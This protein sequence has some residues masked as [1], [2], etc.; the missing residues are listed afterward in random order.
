MD[1]F[2]QLPAK[3]WAFVRRIGFYIKLGYIRTV[4]LIIRARRGEA[5]E[6]HP[7]VGKW[8]GIIFKVIFGVAIFVLA[9]EIAF[10]IGIYK[11]KNNDSVTRFVAGIV[12]YPAA[13]VQGRIV[14]V[15]SYYKNYQYIEKFYSK[16]QQ[17][18]VDLEAVKEKVLAQLID[19]EILRSQAKKY[20]AEVKRS[21]IEDAYSEVVIQN[22]GEEEVKKVLSDLYGLNVKEFK[23]L[24][25]DQI[26]EQK[27]AEAVPVQIRARHILIRV[28]KDAPADKV[29]EAKARIDK[30]LA[31]IRGG[32]DFA[33]A[34]KKYS[35][36]TGS[37]QNGGDLDF[38]SRGQMDADFEKAAFATTVGQIS[39][40]IRTEFGWHIIK[41]EEKKGQVDKSFS[42]WLDGLR[43][44]SLIIK[45]L[46]V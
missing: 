32:L 20:G 43:K 33:E 25:A 22:G 11:A 31:E 42:D 28:D 29:A 34:A 26:L 13:I 3:I 45:L 38:F 23:E 4:A 18:D 6:L 44:E 15:S 24:I 12:P 9:L 40:P 36:D 2:K 16:T 8:A 41:V 19:N 27:L 46:H 14:T 35:E 21:D 7:M 30:V 1:R 17:G 39:D 10:A 37:A 5:L